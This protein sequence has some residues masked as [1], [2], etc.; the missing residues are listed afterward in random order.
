MLNK[1]GRKKFDIF[2]VLIFLSIIISANVSASR[3][4]TIGG[5]S[6]TWGTVL[7]DFLNV[8]H[9]ASGQLKNIDNT[10]D[11]ATNIIGN[12]NITGNIGALN[13]N[14]TAG[15]IQNT[16]VGLG[17]SSGLPIGTGSTQS[18]LIGHGAGNGNTGGIYNTLLGYFAGNGIGGN[19]VTAV[20]ANSGKNN[21]G[22]YLIAIGYQAGQD[23]NAKNV[24]AIGTAAGSSVGLYGNYSIWIGYLAG[25]LNKGNNSIGIGYQAGQNNKGNYS[26]FLGNNAGNGNSLSNMFIVKQNDI[27]SI[28]LIQGNF[29]SGF[30]GIGTA[31]P[32]H[33]LNVVGSA[34]ITG[35]LWL[36]GQNFTGGGTPA[37]AIMAFNL[38]SCPTGWT[39][40]TSTYDTGWKNTSDWTNANLGT[41]FGGN[42]THSLNAP[43]SELLINLYLSTDGTDANSFMPF[44]SDQDSGTGHTNGYTAFAHNNSE[45]AIHT[46]ISGI[47]FKS[48]TGNYDLA[49]TEAWYYKVVVSKI[50][51][52]SSGSVVCQ[53]TTEDTATSNTIWA[54][55]GN[56]VVL[57]N[58]SKNVVLRNTTTLEMYTIDSAVLA[59]AQHQMLPHG[60]GVIPNRVQISLVCVTAELGYV[61]GEEVFD[62]ANYYDG[63]NHR[64]WTISANSTHF[65]LWTVTNGVPASI[66]VL[67]K[68]AG[69]SS[70]ITMGNWKFRIRYGL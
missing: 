56:D 4:P 35:D 10:V 26:I 48:L 32:T 28:P 58:Q 52:T 31:N 16:I 7:N 67:S 3:L 8:S 65:D 19:V 9:N 60:L 2:L 45:F 51:R 62:V 42:V 27:N 40:Y 5:D 43:L 21:L 54:E 70:A 50:I 57:N 22:D 17:A 39:A 6:D 66:Q 46:G 12:L 36:R 34:N 23:N 25:N 61:A 44:D 14:V 69:A 30:V 41:T 49:D 33:T 15:S 53:K 63:A 29:S 24:I 38:A 64:L 55:S 11:G 68:N 59:T 37:G 13:L 18:T 20:G 47:S 1:K